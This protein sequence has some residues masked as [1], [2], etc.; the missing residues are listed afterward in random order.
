[1]K[2]VNS[3]INNFTFDVEGTLIDSYGNLN[4]GAT[5][6]ISNILDTIKNPN[7]TLISDRSAYDTKE[8]IARINQEFASLNKSCKLQ[9]NIIGFGGADIH[10][11]RGNRLISIKNTGLPLNSLNHLQREINSCD[12]G[13]VIVYCTENGN[14]YIQPSIASK[15]RLMASMFEMKE[16]KKGNAGF[17][18]IPCD[19]EYIFE[20]PQLGDIY[21][22]E[23]LTFNKES[24]KKMY[25][26]LQTFCKNRQ[27]T[28]NAGNTIQITTRSRLESLNYLYDNLTPN[29]VYV[30]DGNN[31]IECL[32]YFTPS[33]AVGKNLQALSSANV[34]I[35][36]FEQIIPF[37]EKDSV[38]MQ[39]QITKSQKIIH[40]LIREEVLKESPS[41]STIA[42]RILLYTVALGLPLKILL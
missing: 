6:F 26:K 18:I 1:M 15:A 21:S 29:M 4:P 37:L 36:D 3:D 30:G 10:Q 42:K 7:I 2:N 11:A 22:L 35:N 16:R 5:S 19:Y 40:N 28:I 17:Q 27:L 12:I 14:F 9:P 8:V 23:I 34:A 31:D 20:N 24:S 39:E 33:F 38:K 25:D 41:A 32:K 13:G